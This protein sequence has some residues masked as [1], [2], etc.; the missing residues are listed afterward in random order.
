MTRKRLLAA[1]VIALAVALIP[2]TTDAKATFGVGLSTAVCET[3]NCGY[4]SLVDC[5]CPDMQFPNLKP[6]CDE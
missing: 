2:V 4:L 1:A 5:F 6:Q 3:G